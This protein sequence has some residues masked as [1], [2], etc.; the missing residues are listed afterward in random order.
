MVD[1]AISADRNVTKKEA[2]NKFKYK[3]FCIESQRMWNLKSKITP[4]IIVATGIVTKSLK[5]NVETLPF[6][7]LSHI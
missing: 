6:H 3:S 4:V 5:K 1:E 7:T 2:K